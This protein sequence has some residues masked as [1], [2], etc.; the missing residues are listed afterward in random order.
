MIHTCT[1]SDSESAHFVFLINI[2]SLLNVNSVFEVL[3]VFIFCG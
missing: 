1:M 3:K 2:F